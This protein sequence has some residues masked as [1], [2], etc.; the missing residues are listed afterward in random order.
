MAGDGLQSISIKE[1]TMPAGKINNLQGE[2]GGRF[3]DN[4]TQY[5]IA[6]L[7]ASWAAFQVI[8]D[9]EVSAITMPSYEN[10]DALVGV[11]LLA[12][13]IIYGHM[14]SITLASGTVQMFNNIDAER[15]AKISNA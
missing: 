15:W 5:P 11:T 3:I 7:K 6:P 10:S 14:T 8:V 1:N 13:T 2:Q 4:T 9:A 12:G